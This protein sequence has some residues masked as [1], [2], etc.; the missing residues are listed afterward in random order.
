MSDS[1]QRRGRWLPWKQA[2]NERDWESS[3]VLEPR[4]APYEPEFISDGA[5]LPFRP[6]ALT[7]PAEHLDPVDPPVAALEAQLSRQKPAADGSLPRLEEFRILA[8][9]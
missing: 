1:P 3:L 9:T 2:P 7:A 8:R 6:S 4:L 5:G